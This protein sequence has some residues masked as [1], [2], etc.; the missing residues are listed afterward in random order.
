M[1]D[2]KIS[3]LT[4]ATTVAAADTFIMVQGGETRKV[5]GS[6]LFSNIPVS[7]V[8]KDT[9]ETIA[10]GVISLTTKTTIIDTAVSSNIT[11]T[12][13]AGTHGLEKEIVV[14][15]MTPSY[16]GTLTVT[17]GVGVT[18]ITFNQTGNT[19][20]LKNVSGYWYVKGS[21]GVTIA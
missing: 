12:L 21:K 10:S 16:T 11:L 4:A 9:P 18:T 19:V 2:R 8:V 20:Y 17:S 5:S 1:T 7:P 6:V 3:E 13:A 15:S 14:K